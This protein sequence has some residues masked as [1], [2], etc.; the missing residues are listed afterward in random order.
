MK[1]EVF[2]IRH[3]ES[4]ANK[5][6]N[7]YGPVHWCISDPA[8]TPKGIS[9]T[10]S[11]TK[12]NVDIVC[13]SELL[14]AKQTAHYAYPDHLIY[15]IPG[16]KELGLGLDNLPLKASKYH[17]SF[18]YMKIDEKCTS[19]LDYLK[20]FNKNTSCLKIALFTHHRFIEKYTEFKNCK[21]N[22]F[23]KQT[24]NF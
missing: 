7:T 11:M 18:I 17:S 2:F 22:E 24:Y 6:Q 15:V 16:A 13:C 8:L 12:P 20:K 3:G 1:L 23:V 4:W 10:I 14:R 5:I 9:D 19:F 21:N